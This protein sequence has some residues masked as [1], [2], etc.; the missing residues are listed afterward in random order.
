MSV[1]EIKQTLAT[2]RRQEQ[3]EV[4]AF[5]FRLR[6]THEG[7]YLSSVARRLQDAEPSHW[8]SPDE[9]ERRLDQKSD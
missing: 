2:L 8:L 6:H 3:D 9:F 5:L 1:Q 4:I 7:D